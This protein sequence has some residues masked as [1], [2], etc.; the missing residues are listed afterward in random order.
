M[1][2]PHKR[3]EIP[4][5]LTVFD[6]LAMILHAHRAVAVGSR[7]EDHILPPDTIPQEPGKGIGVD[8]Y[9]TDMP[10][11]KILVAIGHTSGNYGPLGKHR[12]G[13]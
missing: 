7:N 10:K 6:C 12:P 8:E 2:H 1:I 3:I 11:V 9:A 13:P 5:E 4:F